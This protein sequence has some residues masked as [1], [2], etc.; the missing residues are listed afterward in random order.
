MDKKDADKIWSEDWTHDIELI[1]TVISYLNLEKSSKILDIGTGFGVMA[2]SLALAGYDVLTGEPKEHD[3]WQEHQKEHN[4]EDYV[5]WKKSAKSFG[6]ENNIKFRH[7]NAEQLPFSKESF[8]AVFLY[9]ALQHIIDKKKALLESIRVMKSGGIVCIIEVNDHG[10]RYYKENEAFF[11]IE[12][13][14]PRDFISRDKIA[15]E[16]IP[17]DF[18]DAYILRKTKKI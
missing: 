12:K 7:F 5:D 13:V 10:T 16:V 2:I 18:S 3:E 6:V 1:D 15:V 11:D 9:D 8:D 14:D 4:W 17:D